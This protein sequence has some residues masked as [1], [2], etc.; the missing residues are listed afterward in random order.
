MRTPNADSPRVHSA[1]TVLLN[2]AAA[3]PPS[4]DHPAPA[5]SAPTSR[6][7][8]IAAYA[9]V[10]VLL[11]F[12]VPQTYAY[13]QHNVPS[14][15]SLRIH[16]KGLES[17]ALKTGVFLAYMVTALA[18][19]IFFGLARMLEKRIFDSALPLIAG[20][21]VGLYCLVVALA[22]VPV[23]AAAVLSGIGSTQRSAL[24]YVYV[25][26]VGLLVPL[27]YRRTWQN[28]GWTH[29][30]VVVLTS[31]GLAALTVIG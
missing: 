7:L 19:A 12:R 1:P 13:L 15:L 14:T 9:L 4:A 18:V 29:G 5:R 3:A 8:L 31:F 2:G 11:A 16:D 25:F 23:Q 6:T 28:K 26:C 22:V 30:G 10:L 17:L 24:T 27:L 20:T 21:S